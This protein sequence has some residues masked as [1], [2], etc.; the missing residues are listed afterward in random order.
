MLI[1]NFPTFSYATWQGLIII[2]ADKTPYVIND[3]NT[4]CK[5]VYWETSNPYTLKATDEKLSVSASRYLIYFNDG[6]IASEVPQ[7]VIGIQYREGSGVLISKIAGQVNELDGKYYAIKEDIDGLEKIIG[8]S[9]ESEDGS[10]VDRV[11]K[12]EQTAEGTYET[13]KQVETTYY[14]DKESERLRDGISEALIAMATALGEYQEVV[15]SACEDFKITDEEKVEI[16]EAQNKF[17]KN[18]NLAFAYHDTLVGKIATDE[19]VEKIN[20]LNYAKSNLQMAVTNLNTNVN[21]SISDNTVVPSEITIM[22]NMFGNIGVKA[23][24]YKETLSEAI[25]LGIGGEVVE[26]IF[27][28]TKTATEFNQ[29]MA[30][31]TEVI[32]PETGLPALVKQNE[33]NI[34]QTAEN[35]KLNYV[36]FDKVTSEIT[37]ADEVIK[38]DAGTVLM[39]GTLTWDSLD[40]DAKS[41]LKGEKGDNG[42]A[43]YVMLT[44]DQLIKYDANGNPSRTSIL[45]TAMT[46]GITDIPSIIWKYKA[47]NSGEWKDIT[48][49]INKTYY[50]L[51]A[52]DTIWNDRDSITIRVIVNNTY[53]DDFTVVKVRDGVDGTLA[54]YVEIDGDNIF[55]YTIKKGTTVFTP[56]PSVINL[57]G[58]AHNI[59][60]TNTKWYYR[61]PS[62]TGWTLMSNYN[63]KFAMSISP[64]DTTLFPNDNDVV[65]IKF[66]LNTHSDIKTITKLY[67]GQDSVMAVLSNEN[68]AIPCKSDGTPTTY[69]G[70]TT[71]LSIYVGS[72]NDTQNWTI[73]IDT[74][75]VTGEASNNN[76]TFTVTNILGD[77]G[78]VDFV[79][80]KDNFDSVTKRFTITKSKNGLD[81]FLGEDSISYWIVTSASAIVKK[82]D[83]TYEPSSIEIN[84][85]C[86]EGK[87]E[88][89][90][91]EGIFKIY[92]KENEEWIEKYVSS[93][94]ESKYT[95]NITTSNDIKVELYE[96]EI[97]IDEEHIP[98]LTDGETTPV[99]FLDNDSHVIPCNF[100]GI[101][102]NY[103]G[104]TTTIHIYT[105]SV[106]DSENWT[107]SMVE[108]NLHGVITNNNRTYTVT[109]IDSDTAYIDIIAKKEGFD[110][111]TRRFTVTKAI[112][113]TDGASAK[114][115]YIT[116][117]QVFKY[118]ENFEGM[119]TPNTITLTAT[120]HN[121]DSLG[122][123]QYKNGDT[124]T[125]M[126]FT[127][128]T[129]TVTPS[130]GTFPTQNVSTFRYI[131][132]DYYDEITIIKISD[133]TNG[134]PGSDG[135]DS[136]Y[137]LLSNENH[138]V[139]CDNEGNYTEE[140]L[141]KAYTEVFVYKGLEEIPFTMSLKSEGCEGYVDGDIVRLHSLT[142]NSAKITISI[143]A[144]KRQFTKVMSISKALQG[145]AGSGINVLGTL[146][147]ISSLPN[148]G[149]INDAY[150]IDGKMYIWSK[151]GEWVEGATVGSIKGDK[152]TDGQTS[153]FHIK[154]ANS[155]IFDEKGNVTSGEWTELNGEEVGDWIGFYTD[156]YEEDSTEFSAYKWKDIKGEQGENGIVVNLTNDSH[157]IPCNSDGT[158][159]ENSFIGCETKISL[160]LGAEELDD[161]VS[162]DYEVSDANIGVVFD[163]N[164]GTC[165]VEEMNNIDSGIITLTAYYNGVGYS[166]KFSISKNKQG[167]DAI[168]INLSN[169][170]HTFLANSEGKI[171][172]AQDV[173]I[174]IS[175]FKGNNPIGFT[176]GGLPNVNGLIITKDEVEGRI[177][178]ATDTTTELAKNGT[179]NIPIVIEDVSYIKQFSYTR[180]DSGK[181]G[182]DGL[183]GYTVYLTNES[184][185]FYCESNGSVLDEQSTVTTVKAY[186]GAKEMTPTIGTISSVEGLSIS[187]NGATITIKTEGKVLASNGS[188]NIP[189]TVDNKQFIKTF[190]WSKAFKGADGQDGVSASYVVV[191]GD[192]VFKYTKNSTTPTPSQILLNASRFNI[193]STSVGKWQYKYNGEYVDLGVSTNILTVTPSTGTLVDTGSCTFRYIV[194]D[195]Y[196]EIT[197]VEVSDGLDGNSGQTFYTWIMYADDDKGTNISNNPTNKKYIGLSYNN[198]TSTEST[199]PTKYQWSLIKGSD[200]VAGAKGEDGV[201]YY[202]WIKYSNS[203]DG[204]NMYDTPNTNT[205]YIG[206]AVNKTVQTESTNKSDYKW[207][208]FRGDDG[209]DGDDAYTVI[210][211]NENH[212]F[213]AESDG[214]IASA[215]ST[216]CQVL[217]YKGTNAIAPTI[218]SITNPSGMTITKSGTTL[219]ITANAGT[220][221]AESGSVTIPIIVDGI[222]FNR[223]FSWTKVRK[224]AKGDKGDAGSDAN[225]PDWVTQWDSGKTT[226]N[227]TTVLAPKI[228]AGSVSNGKPTGV[229]MGVNVFGTSGTYSNISGIAGYK[230]GTKMYH[231]STDGSVLFGNTN[232]QYISWDGSN[233]KINVNSLSISSNDVATVNAMN[234]AISTNNTTLAN[235]YATKSEVTATSIVNKVV[236]SESWTTL[237][238]NVGN[239]G[240][241]MS[242]AESKL[243]KDSLTTTIGN[244][245]TTSS[246]VNGKLS[247]YATISSVQQTAE[248]IKFSFLASGGYNK[249]RNSSF[250]NGTTCWHYINWNGYAG[251]NGVAYG[252][253]SVIGAG[254]SEWGLHNRNVLQISV[255]NLQVA[256]GDVLGVG[257]QSD[258]IWG[259]VNWTF[260]CLLSSHRTKQIYLEVI[261]FDSKGNRMP[262]QN[263]L[264]LNGDKAG[265]IGNRGNRH[266][267]NW[268]FDLKNPGC[269]YFV[270]NIWMGAWNG[271]NTSAYFWLAEPM[272]VLGHYDDLIY[273][274]NS[275]ELYSGITTIDKDGIIVQASNMNGYSKMSANGFRVHKDGEDIFKVNYQ[276]LYMKGHGEFT[277]TI[278]ASTVDGGTVK[279]ATIQ[280]G[281]ITGTTIEGGS[282][283]GGSIT[284]TTINNGNGTFYVTWDGN[285]SCRNAN[286]HGYIASDT[287]IH[288]NG[289]IY[290]GQDIRGVGTGSA[291]GLTLVTGTGDLAVRTENSSHSVYIQPANGEAKVTYPAQPGNYA[292]LRLRKLVAHSTIYSHAD[293]RG[294]TVYAN[295]VQLTSDRDKKRNI[296]DYT[297]DALYEI[298]TTPIRTY[299]LDGDLDEEIKRIGIIMQEAPLNAIDIGGEGVDLYQMLTMAWKAIQQL[300][301]ENDIL[302]ED[303]NNLKGE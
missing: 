118:S 96:D 52:N 108:T 46:S 60:T 269:A 128:E 167:E 268:K 124:Y 280:G 199:D 73:S 72:I 74:N 223:T 243:T 151:D 29:R 163:S 68:H 1:S 83:E 78:Y 44:G 292:D 42:S 59:T 137:I 125:D 169:E 247:N 295:G 172:I 242:S 31:I 116:G 27:S 233:L 129:L 153:Y 5:Y 135:E 142:D 112:N 294:N 222:R 288:A 114:Y 120:K 23:N 276:G 13:I 115:I 158:T 149:N 264:V 200:G 65:Q 81:G 283:K 300:K 3:G 25:I 279:G 274:E 147:D 226:I 103:E 263:T 70:A 161:G 214:K 146:A 256:N 210:L 261:E 51:L 176:I 100:N 213:V 170:N 183:D 216:T 250:K 76:K 245:Y 30:N 217:S 49:N 54:E 206:I 252:G 89:S 205:E 291:A 209:V 298:C 62:D 88:V 94:N 144:E 297:E 231:L 37:V 267:V 17:V 289:G 177:V 155:I 248:N 159:N 266:K 198:E 39:T 69:V 101:P 166:K 254:T 9:T 253:M 122:K 123:W 285:M 293:V 66:E 284:G 157:I 215:I 109:G 107:Y 185:S 97:F 150:L 21:T 290:T 106:D 230:N 99:A 275:E 35:I 80:L 61:R 232:G 98:I 126:G 165:K 286:I 273:T 67:D 281:S 249:L 32:D 91:Y 28:T 192:Q 207:S 302:R 180:V 131:A 277:G 19:N 110:D 203:S 287:T 7:D 2:S 11:N 208:K 93:S 204:S 156:F 136:I 16:Q 12:L 224:G 40:D 190:S 132:K 64:N 104:A 229:A 257:V 121:I 255:N 258:R 179:I 102:L 236:A 119:P 26:N 174:L 175:V 113:G 188:F 24:D 239:L 87:Q 162:Y 43:Q 55:K 4:D 265:G 8:S 50:S 84:A 58:K 178:I 187:K 168:T 133:G 173:E 57:E 270:I 237:N 241:R 63:G 238:N 196:D 197:V 41:N 77:V 90:D 212:G 152:G 171:E 86:K 56:T 127:S 160:F 111:I 195:I 303:I 211:T 234:N 33:T 145:G 246:D 164:T 71:D 186:F 15:S 92:E 259:G 181:D 22:L 79:A 189:I 134:L 244:Y 251:N 18:A 271:E 301:E 140:D 20:A 141:E 130:S 240:T 227:N 10:I 95:Y 138:S 220:S 6:G 194:D 82:E 143:I 14:K 182:T 225:V 184:H 53:Y 221:L 193:P 75:G 45:I 219:T 47:E 36:K 154:Y 48:S 282:I 139:P 202:T 191:T 38:L 105:G 272:L 235:T 299:H 260:S 34:K 117:E 278:S 85:K 148:S 228:F 262:L 296:E 201:T 218:G